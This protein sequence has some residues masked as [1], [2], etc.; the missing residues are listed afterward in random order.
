MKCYIKFIVLYDAETAGIRSE[1]PGKFR[2][3][4]L[5]QNGEEWTDLVENDE[6]LYGI[7]V[8]RNILHAVKRRKA[9]LFGCNLLKKCPNW[10]LLKGR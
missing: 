5:Q 9:D 3:M 10:T 7:K 2:S 1:I 6:M 8:E 4:V